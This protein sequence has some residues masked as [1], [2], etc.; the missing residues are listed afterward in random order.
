VDNSPK[1][2]SL[3]PILLRLVNV[4]QTVA[5]AW[6]P[7]RPRRM[8]GGDPGPHL[9]GVEPADAQGSSP[10]YH[11]IY[12]YCSLLGRGVADLRPDVGASGMHPLQ[13]VGEAGCVP[14]QLVGLAAVELHQMP[15]CGAVEKG[16]EDA[17]IR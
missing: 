13:G 4:G 10:T 3:R 17:C 2:A 15:C 12:R 8:R 11:I 14:E 9:L 7:D 1:Q 6:R 5:R 16:P